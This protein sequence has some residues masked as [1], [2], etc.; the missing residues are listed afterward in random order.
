MSMITCEHC[1]TRVIITSSGI[2]PS[3]RQKVSSV[4]IPPQPVARPVVE[5][6]A[7]N[8]LPPEQAT[9]C[10]P[11]VCDCCGK[12]APDVKSALAH[13]SKISYWIVFATA[14]HFSVECMACDSCTAAFKAYRRKRV[15]M[16]VGVLLWPIA[17]IVVLALAG[18]LLGGE[19]ARGSASMIFVCVVVLLSIV[20]AFRAFLFRNPR[21]HVPELLGTRMN[22]CFLQLA[23]VKQWGP[24]VVNI[25]RRPNPGSPVVGS[26]AELP[27]AEPT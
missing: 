16:M 15:L 6:V 12:E 1:D 26:T 21:R 14:R 4:A 17:S 7:V 25:N 5:R 22:S 13:I 2:C 23:R 3:C 11:K 19:S 9:I 18:K 10:A 20:W 8:V 27:I 24:S